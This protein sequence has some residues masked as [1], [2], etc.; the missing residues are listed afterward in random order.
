M[1]NAHTISES[2][3]NS[4]VAWRSINAIR[5]LSIDAVEK[6]NSG[7]P[8]APMGLAPTAYAL[9]QH[10]LKHAPG[11]PDWADRDRVVLSAGHAS[12]L[13]YSMLHLTGYDLP[14]DEI[15]DFRQW[16]SKTPGHPEYGLTAG[17]EATTGPLGQGLGNAVGFALAEKILANT[18]N[19]PGHEIVNHRTYAICSDGDMMEGVASE[20]ASLAGT[21]QLGKL[22][23]IYDDNQISIEGDTDKAFREDVAARYEAYG[24]QIIEPVD[25]NDLAGIVN[26]LNASD[27]EPDKPSLVTVRSV[28]GFGSP[29][30]AGTGAVHGKAL[31]GDEVAATRAQ[32]GWEYDPFDVPSDVYEHM[33]SAVER[34]ETLS[35]KWHARFDAYKAEYPELADRFLQDLRGLLPDGWDDGLNRLIGSVD[36]AIATRAVSGQALHAITPSIPRL[37][38]GSADLAESNN[39]EVDGRGSFSPEMPDGRNLHFGVREHGMGAVC[40]G[41]ALHGGVIPYAATFLIFSDY[42]RPAIRVGALSHAPCVW[43]FTHDSIGLGEDGPTHQPISQLMGLRMIPNLTVIRPADAAETFEAWRIAIENRSGPTA[44]ILTRQNLPQLPAIGGQGFARGYVQRGAYVIADTEK[45]PE[46]I[47]IG[48]GSETQIALGAALKLQ[49]EGV[50]ARAV[51]MPSWELFQAESDEYRESVLPSSVRS[52]V[53][54]E[55]GTTIGWERYTGFD[56]AT[57]GI[58]RYGASAPGDVVM[59]N[60]GFTIDNVAETAR[61]LL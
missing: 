24:F 39:T 2:A 49:S 16:D 1:S 45:E 13:L 8:G 46:V 54:V 18:F 7:H 6:A 12:M 33:R 29:N 31:G 23:V 58:D 38:G 56:G 32:L 47:I 15:K 53:S 5:F 52:R 10:A 48:T 41:M 21:L 51:S 22:I 20:A 60:L 55:A 50:A 17:V 26:A 42:L 34:G 57:I 9:W 35:N 28:I 27:D 37:I 3:I 43:I 44:L 61:S 40:N 30:F 19:R 14:I 4:D 25:G 59:A 11:T 36:G